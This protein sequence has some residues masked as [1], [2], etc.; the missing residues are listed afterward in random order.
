VT[1]AC[2]G[3]GK[4]ICRECAKEFGFYCSQACLEKARGNVTEQS[5]QRQ[6]QTEAALRSTARLGKLVLLVLGGLV[7]LVAF[8]FAWEVFLDP[9]GKVCWEWRPPTGADFVRVLAADTSGVTV[10]AGKT[11]VVLD[12]VKGREQR[13]FTL[14]AATGTAAT[15]AA[16]ASGDGAEEAA[17]EFYGQAGIRALKDG[18]ILEQ[19]RNGVRRI[20]TDGAAKFTKAHEEGSLQ[21][22][23][24]SPDED[25]AY[26]VVTV[27]A[28]V[29]AAT[30]ARALLK[31][32]QAE[33]KKA[34]GGAEYI[35]LDERSEPEAVKA[36]RKQATS[37][38]EVLAQTKSFIVCLDLQSGNEVWASPKMKKG[39]S[40]GGLAAGPKALYATFAMPGGSSDDEDSDGRDV[41][42]FAL[43]P[44]DGKRLW[45]VTPKGSAGWGPTLVGDLVLVAGAKGIQ[46]YGA[47]GSEA[48]SI[49]VAE[50]FSSHPALVGGLLWL[51]SE[52]G[53]RCYD[54]VTG[55]E[56]WGVL[57]ALRE[58]GILVC[59]KRV[60][61][62]GVVEESL[63][64]KDM[65]LPAAYKDVE[66]MPEVKAILDQAKR[67][68][69][70]IVMAL[71]YDT[72]E[73]LWRIR[74]AYGTPLGDE[75]RLVLVADTAQ[76]SL[77][78]MATGGKGTTIVR[79]FSGKKGKQLYIRQTDLGFMEPRLLGKRVVGLI[80]E[81]KE[82]ASL[83][84]P[85]SMDEAGP[86]MAPIG[87]AGYRVK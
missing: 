85:G 70:H 53:S 73:E 74:N 8:W 79:Q 16:E 51:T 81:R 47:D 15:A 17:I 4:P 87:L 27:P 46:A 80:Y 67:K 82:R 20:G 6:R 24:V 68:F 12:P 13:T 36:L 71:D 61:V 83:F 52:A 77:L 1:G 57:L 10:L 64:E 29:A 56:K 43:D 78:E 19:N 33:I 86:S 45:Q 38:Y 75:K 34:Y 54:A 58:D 26:Y 62:A 72:G 63:A 18:S 32:I 21:H 35:D 2:V 39:T 49:K 44:A 41:S 48:Y 69:V 76:T 84:K 7:V 66:K 28:D 65:K 22:F 42:L 5:R 11:V 14:P 30:Q 55:Q 59:G 37:A 3:C 23:S 50:G 60:Y 40:V 31:Q 9:A 25:R